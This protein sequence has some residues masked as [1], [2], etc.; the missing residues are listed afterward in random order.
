MAEGENDFPNKLC[1]SWGREN[2]EQDMILIYKYLKICHRKE[3][4]MG[5]I[6]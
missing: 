1:V 3:G 5:S 6:A 2:L 4:R